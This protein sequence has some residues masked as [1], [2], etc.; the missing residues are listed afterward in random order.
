MSRDIEQDMPPS[1]STVWDASLAPSTPSRALFDMD[2]LSIPTQHREIFKAV[3]LATCSYMAGSTFD[4]SHNYEHIQRVVALAHHIYTNERAPWVEKIDPMVV[5]LGAMMHDVGEPKYLAVGQTQKQTIRDMLSACEVPESLAQQVE[6]LVP[7]VSFSREKDI[8][9]LVKA[10]C[11]KCPALKIVQDA[12]RLDSLG[13]VGQARAFAYGGANEMRRT[14]S[15]HVGVQLHCTRFA[16]TVELM[17]T[18][19]GRREAE[20]RWKRMKM[21]LEGYNEEADVSSVI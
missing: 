3:N 7:R 12:D 10:E 11:E 20:S 15:L 13:M 1:P 8:V 4:P 21:F 5:Y 16:L 2:K 14:Q 19:T 9:E 17:K 18:E 6:D